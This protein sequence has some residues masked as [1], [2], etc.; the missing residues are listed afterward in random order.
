MLSH[1]HCHV[2]VLL[3]G[4]RL[5]PGRCI[6][7]KM[8][9]ASPLLLRIVTLLNFSPNGDFPGCHRTSHAQRLPVS[10]RNPLRHMVATPTV[11]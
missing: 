3:F 6:S 8:G 9:L 2:L 4:C 1:H 11:W 10:A 5:G 7:W